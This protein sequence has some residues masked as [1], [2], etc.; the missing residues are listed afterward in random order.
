MKAGGFTG[1]ALALAGLAGC[2]GGNGGGSSSAEASS[3][4]LSASFSASSA[5]GAA[6]NSADTHGAAVVF[7][8]CT[9]NTAAVAEKIATAVHTTPMELFPAVPYTADDLNYNADCRA[10]AEQ[11]EG[12]ARPELAQLIP[13][14]AD[15]DIVYLG[16]PI[17]W[18]KAPRII[19]TFLEQAN[20]A[21]KT[22][23]PFCTSGGSGVE[24]SLAEIEAAAA[25]ATVTDARRFSSSTPQS[26]ID[27][28]VEEVC[29]G[30]R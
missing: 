25:G 21:G 24:G 11:N 2:A 12:A 3:A 19:L 20:V 10:N 7:F 1:C 28:W 18:G 5:A 9:G 13:D 23:V 6:T 15:A 14:V 26:E 30:A 29:Q 8:S 16:Y 22:I 17:W 27:A 4:A